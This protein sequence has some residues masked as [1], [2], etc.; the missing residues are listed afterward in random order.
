MA[1][2]R[3]YPVASCESDGVGNV[4]GDRVTDRIRKKVKQCA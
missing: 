2:V 3:C 4:E 1:T